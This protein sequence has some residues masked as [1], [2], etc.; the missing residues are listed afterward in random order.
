MVADNFNVGGGLSGRGT[1]GS[2]GAGVRAAAARIAGAVHRTALIPVPPRWT[3]PGVELHLKL[4]CTQVA[5]A[6]KARGARHFLSRSLEAAE[7]GGSPLR[8]VVTYSSGNH[9]RAVAEVAASSGIPALITVP[10]HV[11]RSK[12]AAIEAS[13]AELVLAGP[14][15]ESR[16][17]RALEIAAER[18][19]TVVPPF[20]H[21]WIIDGQGTATREILDDLPGLTDLWVP[22]GGG[23][24][25]AGAARALADRSGSVRL[26]TVEPRH[27][28][29]YARS[30]AEGRRLRLEGCCS[31]ADGLLPLEIGVLNWEALQR[32]GA[33][34]VMVEEESILESLRLLHGELG[35][36]PEPSGAVSCTPLLHPAAGA[37]PEPGVHVAIVSG[38][39]VDPARLHS[40]LTT[41]REPS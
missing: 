24:L 2:S 13:G 17:V 23:G 28:A 10:D 12:A 31:M 21:D 41:G 5:G 7:R 25:A 15:S 20:D 1:G 27:A 40:L 9:G 39:N 35:I 14:T 16:R 19:W 11:D 36:G 3:P 33:R 37:E 30:A 34:P 6:F 26:H 18:G 4:E 22:V 29:A 32:Y 38:G 8:G